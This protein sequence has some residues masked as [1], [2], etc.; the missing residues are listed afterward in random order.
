M[1]LVSG[2]KTVLVMTSHCTHS[3]EPKLVAEC[4]YPLTGRAVVSRVY[5]DLAVIDVGPDGFELREL[6]PGVNLR[7][8][9]ERTSAPVVDAR[10]DARTG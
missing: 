7:D 10:S 4:R 5:T 9:A 2:A 6:A 3:G 8:V 1:D